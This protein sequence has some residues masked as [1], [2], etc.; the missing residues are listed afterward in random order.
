MKQ[1]EIFVLRVW[2]LRCLHHFSASL[3]SVHCTFY[4][5]LS[6]PVVDACP[7]PLQQ[8]VISALSSLEYLRPHQGGVKIWTVFIWLIKAFI[9]YSTR[10]WSYFYDERSLNNV[11]VWVHKLLSELSPGKRHVLWNRKDCKKY[12]D[13]A[14]SNNTLP[15]VCF[16]FPWF[17]QVATTFLEVKCA[18]LVSKD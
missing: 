2:N 18:M 5:T 17:L 8:K 14:E 16:W 7:L 4:S 3:L 13:S 9:K 1:L 11:L 12:E 10:T 15:A 6:L